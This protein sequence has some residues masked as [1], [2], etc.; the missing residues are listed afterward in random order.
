MSDQRRRTIKLINTRDRTVTLDCNHIMNFNAILEGGPGHVF[1]IGDHISCYICGT[2]ITS[3]PQSNY[4][5]ILLPSIPGHSHVLDDMG[6]PTC[7]CELIKYDI[8]N[9]ALW[10]DKPTQPVSRIPDFM[11][12]V[13]KMVSTH[14]EKNQDYASDNNPFS[15]FDASEYGLRMFTN[16]RDQA[17]VW[18]IFTKLA[19]LSTLL[20][21]GNKP[22]NES[23]EDSF[24][25]I[26]NYIL[27]WKADYVMNRLRPGISPIRADAAQVKF[28][29]LGDWGAKVEN[30]EKTDIKPAKDV[31]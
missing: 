26:A 4:P 22:N 14:I 10:G 29:T 31:Y 19:R 6:R 2:A 11:K 21:S 24:I 13:E 20:N 17:F 8:P 16:A 18:P 25:D 7:G 3:T 30:N 12:S 28:E 9:Q 23:I 1:N 27:L 15:N 5:L